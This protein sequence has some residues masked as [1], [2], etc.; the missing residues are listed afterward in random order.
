VTPSAQSVVTGAYL[1]LAAFFCFALQDASVKWLVAGVAVVQVLFV[2]SAV[3]TLFLTAR[4]P[5]LWRDLVLSPYRLALLL[6]GVLLL[7]AWVSYYT[8]SRQLQLA[9]MTTIYYASPILVTV[10]SIL[11]LGERVPGLRWLVAALGFAGVIIACLPHDTS[12]P[13]A[14]ALAFAAA[15]LWS[16]SLT[17]MRALAARVPSMLQMLA[18]NAILLLACAVFL[19]WTWTSVPWT[20]IGLMMGVGIIGGAGQYLI[21]EAVRRAPASVTAPM[22]Y[23]S[24]IWAF[25][26]GMLIWG[27][28]PPLTVFIGGAIILASGALLIFTE[29]RRQ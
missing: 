8:A 28:I 24:L 3:I 27:D 29:R 2:R 17:L 11:F 10:F 20:Q 7:G 12:H 1:A 21:F 18:Q 25:L 14:I 26:L 15:V 23:T 6:R 13:A 4:S 19:P 5:A 9:E 16:V 22:E